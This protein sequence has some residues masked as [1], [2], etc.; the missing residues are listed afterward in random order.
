M[1]R[2]AVEKGLP[3]DRFL[4][5]PRQWLLPLREL[6]AFKKWKGQ[7]NPSRLIHGPM[8]GQVTEESASFW[9]RTDGQC[10]IGVEVTGHSGRE[11]VTTRKEEGYVG[12]VQIDGLLP[13]TYFAYEIF[14]N[15]EKFLDPDREF[16]FRTFPQSEEGAKFTVA[17]GGCSGFVPEYEPIWEVIAGHDPRATLFLGDNVYID[18]PE[19]V[20]WTGDYLSLIHI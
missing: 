19:D 7:I 18:D 10:E 15:G 1:A 5:E 16:G 13:G 2:Q 6:T 14:V 3:F 12:V 11:S 4:S 8:V 9:F 20:R 17:F